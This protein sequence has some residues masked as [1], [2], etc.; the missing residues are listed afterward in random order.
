M[1]N[2]PQLIAPVVVVFLED[3]KLDLYMI[4]TK[5]DTTRR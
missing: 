3:I 2:N 5:N 1:V 4:A